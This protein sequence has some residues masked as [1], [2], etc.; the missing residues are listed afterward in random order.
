MAVIRLTGKSVRAVK[1]GNRLV[2][3]RP[4]ARRPRKASAKAIK[5]VVMRMAE[6]KTQVDSWTMTPLSQQPLCTSAANNY[7]IL[8]PS[9]SAGSYTIARGT[10]QAQMEGNR[11]ALQ[12]CNV[13][14]AMYPLPY[15][16]GSNAG[17]S[18]M[19][20]RMYLYRIKQLPNTDPN[21]TQTC[22]VATA[23]FFKAG[24]T[25]SG[26]SGTVFDL[27]QTMNSDDY[28]YLAHKDFKLGNSVP[29]NGAT[30]TSPDYA[31][32]N[33]DFPLSHHFNW[34]VTKYCP[35]EQTLDD[36]GIW[37]QPRLILFVQVV[38]AD[39]AAGLFV[40]NTQYPLFIQG[41]TLYNYKD[42]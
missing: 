13:R 17:V 42:F 26:F 2:V 27:C 24:A 8:N 9:N 34:N 33:N 3:S 32:S 39:G 31:F 15:N 19:L 21:S 11:I 22:A 30:S 10:G 4:K 29:Q 16:A 36:T 12:S 14:I 25:Y 20:V 40:F 28:T 23:N 38:P 6:T 37:Q 5:K 1:R 18:P 35:K 7:V 41:Q